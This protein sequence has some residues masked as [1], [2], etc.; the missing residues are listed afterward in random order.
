MFGFS[1][2]V[3]NRGFSMTGCGTPVR[4]C[5]VRWALWMDACI[6]EKANASHHKVLQ[7]LAY[8]HG[9]FKVFVNTRKG[10]RVLFPYTPRAFSLVFMGLRGG[11]CKR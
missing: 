6:Q 3:S 4:V 2:C 10:D 8:C 11:K 5:D 7:A 1:D 9:V